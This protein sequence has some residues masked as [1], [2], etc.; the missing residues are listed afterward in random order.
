M[1]KKDEG[2]KDNSDS[3]RFQ[4]YFIFIIWQSIPWIN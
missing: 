4:V 1:F 3:V 2:V